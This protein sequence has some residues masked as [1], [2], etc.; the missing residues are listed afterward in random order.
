MEGLVSMFI[1]R[2]LYVDLYAQTAL[3]RRLRCPVP[4]SLYLYY[5]YK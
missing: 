2:S 5:Q 4:K 3:F 1:V